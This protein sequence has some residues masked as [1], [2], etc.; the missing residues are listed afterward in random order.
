[1]YTYLNYF[2]ITCHNILSNFLKINCVKKFKPKPITDSGFEA[3]QKIEK[4][5]LL[6]RVI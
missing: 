6:F 4:Y 2:I 5:S 1:M 3:G